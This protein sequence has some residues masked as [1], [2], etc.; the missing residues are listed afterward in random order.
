MI[1]NT[2]KNKSAK[3][4]FLQWCQK[5]RFGFLKEL[6]SEQFLKEQVWTLL[7]MKGPLEGFHSNIMEKTLLLPQRTFQGTVLKMWI[8]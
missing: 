6:F 4:E 2:I 8:I 7:K 5:N 1:L 3:R